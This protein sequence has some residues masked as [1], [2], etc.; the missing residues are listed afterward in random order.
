MKLCFY[1]GVFA[2]NGGIEEFT[3]DLALA[4]L[5][6]GVDV[7]IVCASLKHPLLEQLKLAG[8][9]IIR[10]PVYHGCRWHIPDYA[11]FLFALVR[12]ARADVVVHRK[13]HP[14]LVYRFLSKKATH[15]YITAYR[16]K[17]QLPS[18]TDREKF[19]SFFDLVFTQ[20]EAFRNDLIECGLERPIHVIPH[21]PPVMHNLAERRAEK[22]RVL[23]VGMMGRLE[24]QKNPLY[25][26]EIALALRQ[27][28][29][30][31]IDNVE[32]HV[33]GTGALEQA[34]R[35]RAEKEHLGCFFHGRYHRS[36]VEEIVSENDLFIITSVTEGQCIVAL[37]VLAGGRPLFAT[38]V[39]ALPE[40][41]RKSERGALLP[42]NAAAAA[43]EC[44]S[45]WMADKRLGAEAIQRSYYQ[46]YNTEDVKSRYVEL[47]K[48]T[49]RKAWHY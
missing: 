43:A 6:S 34:M 40:I 13:P 36:N 38:P 39:G 27:T 14:E 4:L 11:L 2:R 19:F 46:D 28:P 15:I 16:P 32:F 1:F 22:D 10:V 17:E 29:P 33:Y 21:I 24:S 45:T 42:E 18:C 12:V 49:A 9:K 8:A 7:E 44:I 26:M 3:K 31:G 48:K 47:I 37:E 41:L 30:G 35:S 23:R 5:D 25:A 20:T